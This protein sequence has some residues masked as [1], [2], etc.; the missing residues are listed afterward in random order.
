[1]KKWGVILIIGIAVVIFVQVIVLAVLL[2]SDEPIFASSSSVVVVDINDV[3]MDSKPV[4]D[5][6]ELYT[7]RDDVKAIVLRME[8]PGGSVAASQELS[9]AVRRL[10]KKNVTVVTSVGN[11]GASGG[12]YIA[13]QCDAIVVNPGSLV[14]S[15]G[16][17]MEHFEISE[18]TEKLGIKME[19]IASGD[20]K[21][22]GSIS[23][24]MRPDE[25]KM[26]E[27]LIADAFG[28]FRG[29]VLEGRSSAIAAA[30]GLSTDDTVAIGMALDAVADGRILTGQQAVRAGLADELGDLTDAIRVA[31]ELA[32]IKDP[33]IIHDKPEEPWE[34]LSD[35]FGMAKIFSGRSPLS[36]IPPSGL[37]YI[38]R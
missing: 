5:R 36:I 6:L 35:I 21:T 22:A 17:V 1:M 30:A 18:L 29:A 38:Y 24:P 2:Y 37:W 12:Y 10:R 20:M 3:I 4:L 9:S 13:S 7:D 14:G 25:R 16:V 23:R 31:G 33:N 19:A 28:Q 11:L 27:E 32:G 26:L 15:I 8:T 34:Q